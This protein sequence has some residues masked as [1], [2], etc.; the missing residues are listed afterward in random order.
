M[1]GDRNIDFVLR[2][3]EKRDVRFI[4]LWFT[5]V[6]GNLISIPGDQIKDGVRIATGSYIGTGTYGSSHPNS[7]TFEF[8]P[9]AL[10]IVEDGQNTEGGILWINPLKRGRAMPA[11]T[12]N[13]YYCYLTWS[14][15]TVSWYDIADRN[16]KYQHN[17]SGTTYHYIAIG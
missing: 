8:E 9:K 17:V 2:T 11:N 6:L 12:D 5:D 7:L 14:G 1:S 13:S 3:V 15:K 4:R 16:S 10:C